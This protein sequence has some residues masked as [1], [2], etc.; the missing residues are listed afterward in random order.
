MRYEL[1][2]TVTEPQ[3]TY[4]NNLSRTQVTPIKSWHRMASPENMAYAEQEKLPDGLDGLTTYELVQAERKIT[5]QGSE[6]T[7]RAKAMAPRLGCDV[8]RL[9]AYVVGLLGRVPKVNRWDYREELEQTIWRTLVMEADR[10]KG[11]WTLIKLSCTGAYRRWYGK[12][13]AYRTLAVDGVGQAISLDRTAWSESQSEGYDDWSQYVAPHSQEWETDVETA[14]DNARYA[15]GVQRLQNALPELI[16]GIIQ[17]RLDGVTLS[18]RERKQMSRWLATNA[19]T[20]R[21]VLAGSES[22]PILW[23]KASRK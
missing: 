17:R 4:I 22:D 19:T 16:K 2:A 23:R 11:D 8:D 18:P 21:K 13:V 15:N 14:V 7:R 1:D 10:I 12:L 20:V 6:L 3:G 9:T 5:A